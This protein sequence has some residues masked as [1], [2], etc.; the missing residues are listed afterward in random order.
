MDIGNDTTEE[1]G[2]KTANKRPFSMPEVSPV[3]SWPF[4]DDDKGKPPRQEP[5]MRSVPRPSHLWHILRHWYLEIITLLISIILLAAIII[6]LSMYDGSYMP[7]WPFSINLSTVISLLSTFLRAAM[8]AAVAEIIG[9]IKWTWFTERTRPL[10]HLQDFDSASRSMIGSFKLLGVVLW[11]FGLTSAGFLGM[12]AALV[13]ITSLAVGPFTQQALKTAICPRYLPNARAAIPG[14]NYVPGSSSYYRIEPGVYEVEVGM[15][16]AM[17]EGLT[18]PDGK[19]NHIEATCDGSN[20]TWEDYGTG[21]TH[22]T[23]GVCSMC[24]DTTDYVSGPNYGG[25]IT[26][27]D[28]GAVINYNRGEYLWAGYSNLTWASDSFSEAFATASSVAISNF[29]MLVAS[30]STCTKRP[31]SGF[32]DCP[33]NVST[34]DY[35]NGLG[36]YIATSCTLY[37][38]MKEYYGTYN[39]STFKETVV[40]TKVALPNKQEMSDYTAYYNYT[41]LRSPC[42]LTDGDKLDSTNMTQ[43]PPRPNM[44]D[45][46]PHKSN[47][48]MSSMARDT[49]YTTS[50]MSSAPHIP[51]RTWA[52]ISLE[53][54]DGSVYNTS[55]PNACLYKMDGIYASAL[56]YFISNTLFSGSCYYD[57]GQ[58]GHLNCY[59]SWWLS[60]L[61]SD[62]N[63]TVE[64]IGGIVDDF[65]VA[66]TNKLRATGT[67]PDAML[68]DTPAEGFVLGEVYESSTCTYFDSRW[69]SFP[70]V[71]VFICAVLLVW[72]LVKN[73]RDPDQPVWKGSVLPLIYLGLHAPGATSQGQ[74]PIRRLDREGTGFFREKGR[75]A[76]ELGMIKQDAGRMWVRFHGGR[77]PGFMELGTGKNKLDAEASMA[78]LLAEAERGKKEIAT[79][80]RR[81]SPSADAQAERVK[82][83][84]QWPLIDLQP[85]GRTRSSTII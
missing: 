58:A 80:A 41:A 35:Y 77:E 46:A 40:N 75:S 62:M 36:S 56:N 19:D 60:P 34:V 8:L 47:V 49:W 9:Q 79:D 74:G 73:Y 2:R 65:A 3:P 31:N 14:A 53:A 5:A 85:V 52:N 51:G 17:I 16:G 21:V 54:A 7:E 45:A 33:H 43:A 55:V 71:L 50:N 39:G 11:N 20:C 25:N 69:V 66:L 59:D 18:Y 67:G 12:A 29:S 64:S 13:T 24:M 30:T 70:I 15:K 37:P 68:G 1:D 83:G 78:S 44:T 76:P 32:Y 48:N 26:L 84:T 63:A 27:P 22:A 28:Y 10:H 57:M 23:I 82:S 61:F 4:Q 38:C 42:V 72:T 6:L 81:T